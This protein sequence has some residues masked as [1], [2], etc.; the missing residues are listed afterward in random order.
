MM[1]RTTG[2]AGRLR[3]KRVPKRVPQHLCEPADVF[4]PQPDLPA[5]PPSRPR[6]RARNIRD[7]IPNSDSDDERRHRRRQGSL[8]RD[9][10][11]GEDKVQKSGWA[12]DGMLRQPDRESSGE[13][14]E[15]ESAQS[16]KGQ[17]PSQ[18]TDVPFSDLVHED[19]F[20][21]Y[22]QNLVGSPQG[23]Q[24][25]DG[26]SDALA[27]QSRADDH[28]ADSP[29]E[30]SLR[31]DLSQMHG[32]ESEVPQDTL[33]SDH[34]SAY[35]PDEE[36]EEDE[37][38]EQEP[39]DRAP[40]DGEEEED[41]EEEQEP[42]D[43]APSDG[44]DKEEENQDE[45]DQPPGKRNKRRAKEEMAR[46]AVTG[47]L[48]IPS[49]KGLGPVIRDYAAR[50]AANL[51]A[52]KE[53]L[54]KNR[55]PIKNLAEAKE[56]RP[57]LEINDKEWTAK[58]RAETERLWLKDPFYAKLVDKSPPKSMLTM[59]KIFLRVHRCFPEDLIG[60]RHMLEYDLSQNRPFKTDRSRPGRNDTEPV[61]TG[62][63][64]LW[65]GPFCENLYKLSGHPMWQNNLELLALAI[66]YVII[67]DTNDQNPWSPEIPHGDF[68][69]LHAMVSEMN[70]PGVLERDTM[71]EIR[72][73]VVER[74]RDTERAQAR[75]RGGLPLPTAA[76][77]SAPANASPPV[78][79]LLFERIELI[80]D[81]SRP[82]SKGKK[83]KAVCTRKATE[84]YLVHNNHLELLTR[85][86]DTVG[87]AGFPMYPPVGLIHAGTNGRLP[88]GGY[89]NS[90]QYVE[91]RSYAQLCERERI[92]WYK[93][94]M[95]VPDVEVACTPEQ[96]PGGRKPPK[97][98]RLSKRVRGKEPDDVV[99][100]SDD[101]EPPRPKRRRIN[102]K[103]PGATQP[104][105]IPVTQ[106]TQPES[107]IPETQWS[108]LGRLQTRD[109][110][111]TIRDTPEPTENDLDAIQDD[112][113][114]S[115]AGTPAVPDTPDWFSLQMISWILS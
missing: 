88:T 41:E 18:Q 104:V 30:S 75:G 34:E 27:D 105:I 1:L 87:P 36:E 62:R 100:I 78:W 5:L 65:S 12:G 55:P 9:A 21:F 82:K 114:E 90:S 102:K 115:E 76:P 111:E 3:P 91:L 45:Q 53:W 7:E 25:Y 48:E 108:S 38:E 97:G 107:V 98:K 79:S 6:A 22:D 85:A 46:E 32:D 24:G 20:P 94:N 61:K 47:S 64:R 57:R 2:A 72:T 103:A 73:R 19:Q 70:K 66:Q 4:V 95:P 17:E 101:D 71:T 11:D 74:L 67:V 92:A 29:D 113:D 37:E 96:R 93:K 13:E 49:V 68:A 43:R 80:V 31:G 23:P 35:E 8:R 51:K 26:E 84:F 110:S 39:N 33:I 42:N 60:C 44:E 86:L 50:S 77:A 106:H 16:D 63:S 89:P 109:R 10:E 81:K 52:A 54:A 40:S 56:V 15:S 99:V 83:E 59:Y 14:S 58:D 28:L 69:F 112:I